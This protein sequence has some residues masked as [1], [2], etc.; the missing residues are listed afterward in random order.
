[1]HH[2]CHGILVNNIIIVTI[3]N[4]K[5]TTN[6]TFL[7]PLLNMD[8]LDINVKIFYELEILEKVRDPTQFSISYF[9][10]FFWKKNSKKN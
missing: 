5:C 1:M 7:S 3:V 2:A 9:F 4:F 8:L 6:R 10:F